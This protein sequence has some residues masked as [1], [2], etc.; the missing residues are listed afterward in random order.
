MLRAKNAF[1]LVEVMVSVIIIS[2]VILA[3]LEMQGNTNYIFSKFKSKL[4]INQYLSFFIANEEYGFEK[5]SISLDDLLS[6][7][8]VENDLR[9]EL[10]NIKAK[11]IY[12]ELD[13]FDMSEIDEEDYEEMQEQESTSAVVFEIGKTILEIESG[14][15][16]LMRFR[17]Q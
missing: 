15:A 3:L 5:D 4:S 17:V 11:L 6:D 12:E 8:R 14:S 10:K 13:S 16:S 1:T 9:K 2:T 7:F